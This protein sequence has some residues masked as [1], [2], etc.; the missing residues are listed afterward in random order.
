MNSIA[1]IDAN[2][3]YA[4]AEKA[5][6]PGL[7]RRP[8]IVLSNN[9]GCV[10][11]RSK[12][13]KQLGIG[14]GVPV[15]GIRHL[16]DRHGIRV[17]SCNYELNADMSWRFQTVLEDFSPEIEHY[18]ID[19]VF[20]RVPFHGGSELTEMGHRIR[21]TVDGL[22]GIA[23]SIGFAETK[24]LAKIAIELA[25][26]SRKTGGVLDL[27]RSRHQNAAL[28]RVAVGDVW[29]VGPA[30]ATMLER[31]GVKT[32]LELRDA[33]DDWIRRRMT[34]CGLRTVHELRG[35]PCIPFEPTPKTRQMICVSRSFGR[36]VGDLSEIRAAVAWVTGRAA[37]KL[38]RSRLAGGKNAAFVSTDRFKDVPQYSGSV[39]L[40]VAPKSDNT[41][42][43]QA[44]AMMAM[45]KVCR[46]GFLIRKAGVILS[47]LEMID[48]VPLRLW[49]QQ[50]YE[51]HRRL[52]AAIDELNDRFGHET[53][54]CG[55]YPV[56]G[57]WR[58]RFD[59]VSPRYTT[60]WGQI[61]MAK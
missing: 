47:G 35:S 40:E 51:T 13:A 8:V 59:N 49:E 6:D 19:E 14:M 36:A 20:L 34:I 53:V 25:K 31:N 4:T 10:V 42:E 21:E 33:D 56:D 22:T 3:F 32:A 18:S 61:M 44:L 60:D 41:I 12:E 23:V 11:A 2:N 28:E 46:P 38:R 26:S 45:Q 52:M 29:G 58:T 50:R 30:Y 57:P 39:T 9:D 43:L 7:A 17:L 54:R 15:F 37:Q 55:L 24:T 16:V 1:L 27:T 48:K 5:F